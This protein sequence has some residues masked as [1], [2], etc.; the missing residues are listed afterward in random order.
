MSRKP[1][2][3][4]TAHLPLPQRSSP[5]PDDTSVLSC[6]GATV[7]QLPKIRNPS[8]ATRR[9]LDS[10]WLFKLKST[11]FQCAR[12]KEGFFEVI[13]KEFRVSLGFPALTLT[14]AC[15]VHDSFP[16]SV[17]RARVVPRVCACTISCTVHLGGS[18][19]PHKAAV[20]PFAALR[21]DQC[22]C[23]RLGFTRCVFPEV[24]G[25]RAKPTKS[26]APRRV[27]HLVVG[28]FNLQ[29]H[30]RISISLFTLIVCSK[31]MPVLGKNSKTSQRFSYF[32]LCFV[33]I[34]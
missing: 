10:S 24:Q 9:I 7:T 13:W 14:C 33:L 5:L 31:T 28:F 6:P 4:L 8:P 32:F 26:Q 30:V 22:L 3:R 34:A 15:S 27:A 11:L 20:E 23:P 21:V 16:W 17:I 2:C 19:V 25:K 29:S 12:A 1:G 18:S